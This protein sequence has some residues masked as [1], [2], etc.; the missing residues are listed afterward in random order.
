MTEVAYC[1]S[2]RWRA[3]FAASATGLVAMDTNRFRLASRPLRLDN[4]Y[5]GD[6]SR[7]APRN[8]TTSPSYAYA[9]HH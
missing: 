3:S 1:S 9:K 8:K 5:A 4:T 7:M 2:G 6:A